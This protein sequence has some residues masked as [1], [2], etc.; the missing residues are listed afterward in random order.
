[1]G[2]IN[3]TGNQSD[4]QNLVASSGQFTV[5]QYN[6]IGSYTNSPSGV[7][8]YG[9]VLSTRTANHSFQLY[10][11]HT[12]DLAYK[13]QWNNDNYSGWRGIPVYGANTGSPTTRD[14]YSTRVYDANNTAYYSDPHATSNLNAITAAGNINANAYITTTNGSGR[15]ILTGH[16]HFDA[17]NS[18]DFYF[19]YYNAAR[20]KVFNGTSTESF[21]V[22]TDR[23][24]Y[25]YY[26]MRSPIF[27][28]NANTSYYADFASTTTSISTAGKIVVQGGHGT[29]RVHI[30]YQH[31]STDIVNSG[32]L[33]SWVSE[34]GI[35]YN[36]AGIGGNINVSGQYYGR[37]YNSGYGCYVRFDKNN[38]NVEHWTTTGTAGT[39]GGKGTRRW[40]ND[41]AGNAFA[42]GSSRAPI[43]YDA[44]NTAY[45]LDAS[46][47]GISLNVQG[48]LQTSSTGTAV[49]PAL[50][51][52]CPTSSTYIHTIESITANMTSGQ[53]N[54]L[55]IGKAHST[56]NAGYIGYYWTASGSNNNFVT[57]GQWGENHIFRVY[58]DQV[59]STVR[60][61]SDTDVRAP[62]FYDKDD[63]TYYADPNATSVLYNIDV[64][65][66]A[67]IKSNSSSRVLY[68]KQQSSGNGNIIQFQD[69]SANNTW[70]LV[71]RNNGFYLYNNMNSV[72]YVMESRADNGYVA[73]LKGGTDASYHLDVGGTIRATSDVI[74][75]SDRRVKENIVTIDN[76]LEKVTKLRGVSY[77]RKDIKDKSTK[78]GVIAQEVLEVLPEVVTKDND[79]KYSVAYGNMAGVFIEAIKDLKTEIDNLKQEI[80]TLKNN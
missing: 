63:T 73:I 35:T 50:A 61:S 68:L 43:F 1:M 71:G 26:Q 74:A 29:A 2:C 69:Q 30:N 25:A 57:I 44:D 53:S 18:N 48:R 38:G 65:N 41:N 3:S 55:V 13:T 76:A 60:L 6:A 31:S 67:T 70:E 51:I 52:N 66:A 11:A 23:I 8:T 58:G 33:T 14:L 80:K 15:M 9:S 64:R 75:F 20:F 22:D 24:T 72:G 5:T 36:G 32:A 16:F 78:V 39:A 54:I 46:A 17:F 40:Y 49:N 4:W 62:I 28:D 47:T 12:G 21:R 27:Y 45:Y 34:P 59:L 79:D 42:S 19:G 56:K 37:A 7:Y 77:N 10:S